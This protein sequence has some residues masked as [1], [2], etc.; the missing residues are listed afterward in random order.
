MLRK[1]YKTLKNMSIL[2]ELEQVK[3]KKMEVFHSKTKEQIKRKRKSKNKYE[4]NHSKKKHPRT[5]PMVRPRAPI[6]IK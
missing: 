2:N 1:N 6:I 4:G 5:E 3:G